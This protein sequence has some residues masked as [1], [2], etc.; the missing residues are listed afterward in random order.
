MEP[1]LDVGRQISQ[2]LADT[3]ISAHYLAHFLALAQTESTTTTTLSDLPSPVSRV[4][5]ALTSLQILHHS[6]IYHVPTTFYTWSLTRRA[7]QMLSPSPSHL[8]KAVILENKRWRPTH[9][10]SQYYCV[11]VQY[12][13][14]VDTGRL[15]E[16]VRNVVGGDR[17]EKVAKKH[18]NFR[19]ADQEETEKRTGFMRNGVSP[20]GA[21]EMW[22][23]L[24]S[25]EITRLSP[26][27]MWFGGGHVDY[28]LAMPVDTFIKA[29]KCQVAD[30]SVPDE[31]E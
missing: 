26:P 25:E 2:T 23:V 15:M 14:R 9:P 16:Y 6:R 8:C 29:T 21:R 5:Q 4:I 20:F 13:H 3:S 27:V 31:H 12:V 28:K 11:M 19:L 18:F 1:L 10:G 30:I 24:L 17:Q 7:L 22:P